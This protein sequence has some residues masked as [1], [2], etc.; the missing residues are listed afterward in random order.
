MTVSLPSLDRILS[1]L[2]EA[3]QL[4]RFSL[5]EYY[6]LAELGVLHPAEHVELLDGLL[7]QSA[8]SS[9]QHAACAARLGA[10]LVSQLHSNASVQVRQRNPL[11]VEACASE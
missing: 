11:T 3:G 4:R 5:A 7:V 8:P 1:D 2:G 6:R 9:P 10:L